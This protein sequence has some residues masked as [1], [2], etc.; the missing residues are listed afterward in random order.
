MLL[1]SPNVP[2]R[3]E[4]GD[5]AYL[6]KPPTV[7]ERARWRRAI[8]AAGGRRHG[9]IAMLECMADGVRTLM[10]DDLPEVRDPILERI[11]AHRDALIGMAAEALSGAFDDAENSGAEIRA[12]LKDRMTGI[13]DGAKGLAVIESAVSAGYPRYADMAADDSAYGTIAGLEAARLFLVAW[14]GFEVDLQ[15]G[16]AG[17]SE[18]SLAQIPENHLAAIG[19]AVEALTRVSEKKRKNSVSPPPSSPGGETSSTSKDA[20]ESVH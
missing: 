18:Q 7:M 5:R 16:T 3:V 1:V 14:E 9:Q 6:L 15:R 12:A 17:L 10:A 19:N 13:Q 4:I 20:P 11:A 8:V 2:E